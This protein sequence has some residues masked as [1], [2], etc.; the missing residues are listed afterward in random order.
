MHNWGIP[1][2][3]EKRAIR[4]F[5]ASFSVWERGFFML[6]PLQRTATLF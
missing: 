4:C 2:P 6:F 3:A 5:Y 1:R